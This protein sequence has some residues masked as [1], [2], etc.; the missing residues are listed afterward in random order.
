M[1]TKHWGQHLAQSRTCQW[2]LL[3]FSKPMWGA[4]FSHEAGDTERDEVEEKA[5]RFWP[6][7]WSLQN[8]F[9]KKKLSC[10]LC[11]PGGRSCFH[12][13]RLLLLLK[14]YTSH[15]GRM[16]SFWAS[17]RHPAP[18]RSWWLLRLAF[19]SHYLT[20]EY[21]ISGHSDFDLLEMNELPGGR[22]SRRRCAFGA[23]NSVMLQWGPQCW[24]L[25]HQQVCGHLSV[26]GWKKI[27]ACSW[28]VLLISLLTKS[29]GCIAFS[30]HFS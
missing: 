14:R 19:L 28:T 12:S 21:S 6:P 2:W 13:L 24:D 5:W 30:W 27:R 16:I 7:L 8:R 11:L 9:A 23:G 10:Q 20:L 17:R 1:P 29:D 4:L 18:G 15:A 22:R 25:C 26:R 3:F